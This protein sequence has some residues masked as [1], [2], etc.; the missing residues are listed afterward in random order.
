[1]TNAVVEETSV[2]VMSHSTNESG[3]EDKKLKAALTVTF[4]LGE[5]SIPCTSAKA[6]TSSLRLNG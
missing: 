3:G 4:F 6:G 5:E 2:L 1:M